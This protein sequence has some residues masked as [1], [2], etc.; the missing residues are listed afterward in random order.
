VY[1]STAARLLSTEDIGRLLDRARRRNLVEDVAGVLL[2]SDRNFTQCLEGPARNLARAYERIKA[3]SLH[4][5]IV[6]LVREP[7]ASREFAEWSMA[8]RVAGALGESSPAQQDELLSRRLWLSEE[9]ASLSRSL[10]AGFWSRG[11]SSVV[12]S[13]LNLSK[14]QTSVRLR[15]VSRHA[16]KVEAG[17]P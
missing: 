9:P 2:F 11:R 13:L 1:V 4:F 7:I 17:P 10:L 16:R 14:V 5:G 3:D 15:P 12:P 6:D 8:F